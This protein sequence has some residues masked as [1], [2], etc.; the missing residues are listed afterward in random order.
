MES[1][2][3]RQVF[4]VAY[5]A[6]V[7]AV[8]RSPP[9]A[10]VLTYGDVAELLEN[11]GARQVG[12]ARSMSTP[13]TPGWRVLRAGGRPPRGLELRARPHYDAEGTPLLP[14]ADPDPMVYRVDLRSARWSP[15]SVDQLRFARLGAVLRGEAD[16][17]DA[18]P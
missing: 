18:Q 15:S 14:T 2:P 17:T 10:T 3:P 4:S 8:V 9:P 11:G 13:G 16:P 5:V 1:F 12:R 7:F 6:A